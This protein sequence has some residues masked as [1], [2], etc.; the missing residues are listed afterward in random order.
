[1]NFIFYDLGF[2]VLFTLV[3]GIFLYVKRKNLTRQGIMYLYRTKL[4]IRFIENTSKK[5]SKILKPLQYLVIAVG[6]VLMGFMIYF[7]IS[8][9]WSYLT[10]PLLA[11]ALKIPVLLPL[12]PYLPEL[13]K[14]NFLPPFYFTYWII[15]IAIIAI[16]HE[17]SHGIFARLNKIKIHSTGFGF[18]GPFLA[19]FVE[20]DDKQ[21]A[22]ASKFSQLSVLAA[23]TFA[24]ILTAIFFGL[25]MWIFFS[26]SFAPAG[27]NFNTYY[28]DAVNI[29]GITSINGISI[30]NPITIPENASF[31]LVSAGNKTYFVN[32]SLFFVSLAQNMSYVIAYENS[33]AFNANLS[34]PI[35]KIDGKTTDSYQAFNSIILSHKPGDNIT[36]TSLLD[37][38]EKEYQIT[39]SEKEG[40]AFLGTGVIPPRTSGLFGWAY[41]AI[42]KIKD[43]LIY[44]KSS[45]GISGTF[46]YDL[47][48]WLILI[49]L[50]V[51]LVNMIPLGPFDG[52]RFFYLIVLW[53]TGSKKIAEKS[54]KYLTWL[55]IFVVLLLMAKWFFAII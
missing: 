55:L 53:A 9:S 1:M 24:N 26:L 29:S 52:G 44:Y 19:A 42:A 34:S 22:K 31:I 37:G 40:K 16:P 10:S 41:S 25:I 39:L 38:K 27:V 14:L 49:S 18:L 28:F 7:F 20:Q 51:A 13:F 47:L 45:I 48:W 4:G 12:I 23:G 33:P 46:I 43:P 17:F 35:L 6:I 2:F 54:F 15:I 36:I 50:S 8:F 30:G 3:V 32:P 21:M 11:K 5:Y